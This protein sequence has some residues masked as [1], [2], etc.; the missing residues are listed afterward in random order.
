MQTVEYS[1]K[2]PIAG[3][4]WFD[5]N[6]TWDLKSVGFAAPDIIWRPRI[7]MDQS[8]CIHLDDPCN[9]KACIC[10]GGA[11]IDSGKLDVESLSNRDRLLV[12]VIG[13]GAVL[14]D[15]DRWFAQ[16]TQPAVIFEHHPLIRSA[17]LKMSDKYGVPV[18]IMDKDALSFF[19][20]METSNVD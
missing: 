11:V 4:R 10:D 13:W 19:E 9:Q 18:Q 2:Q 17:T 12:G 20:S 8:R 16:Y 6:L 15:K 3:L 5:V 14:Q 7:P 1:E